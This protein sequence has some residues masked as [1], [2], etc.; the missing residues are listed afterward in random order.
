MRKQSQ[1]G[2]VND[3]EVTRKRRVN[4]TRFVCTDFLAPQIPVFSDKDVFF[5]PGTGSIP[6]TGEIYLLLSRKKGELG[7]VRVTFPVLPFSQ[8]PSVLRFSTYQGAIFRD[9]MF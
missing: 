6:F 3:E 2:V 1:S 4:L 5:P 8:T 9:S 7:E